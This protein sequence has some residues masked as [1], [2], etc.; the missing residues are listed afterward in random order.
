MVVRQTHHLLIKVRS[1]SK[2][3][4]DMLKFMVYVNSFV[5]KM[6]Y[7]LKFNDKNLGSISNLSLKIILLQN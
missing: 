3:F 4:E 2:K 6:S 5:S 1:Q 7:H